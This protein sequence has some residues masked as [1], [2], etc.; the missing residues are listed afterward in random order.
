MYI[1]NLTITR[2]YDLGGPNQITVGFTSPINQFFPAGAFNL[3][4]LDFVPNNF[5]NRVGTETDFVIQFETGIKLSGQS[6]YTPVFN[7][8]HDSLYL[9]A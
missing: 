2:T 8:F 5:A 4:R 7:C 3:F 6:V 1:N 9:C